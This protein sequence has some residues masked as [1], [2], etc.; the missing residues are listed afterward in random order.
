MHVLALT[1]PH[2]KPCYKHYLIY[3]EGWHWTHSSCHRVFVHSTNWARWEFV[4]NVPHAFPVSPIAHKVRASQ[5]ALTTPLLSSFL[6]LSKLSLINFIP[7]YFLSNSISL[8][9]SIFSPSFNIFPLH[10]LSTVL[11]DKRHK[12]PKNKS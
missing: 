4:G 7:L 11:S 2:H 9:Q 3:A 12:K 8:L 1:V 5:Q 10:S 6:L